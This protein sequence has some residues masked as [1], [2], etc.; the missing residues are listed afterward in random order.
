MTFGP[1]P[2]FKPSKEVLRL[3]LF[4]RDDFWMLHIFLTRMEAEVYMVET[5]P[6]LAFND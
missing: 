5:M 3:P 1:F 4:D 2:D 6:R